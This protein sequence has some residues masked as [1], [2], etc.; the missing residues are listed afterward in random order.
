M[1]SAVGCRACRGVWV[2]HAILAEMILVM[3]NRLDSEGP[4]FVARPGEVVACLECGKPMAT[5]SLAGA[6]VERCEPH[7]VWFD[8]D[9]LELALRGSARH[10]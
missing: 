10:R 3:R 7:G 4:R 6:W 5:V 1:G 2:S 8:A 9:E